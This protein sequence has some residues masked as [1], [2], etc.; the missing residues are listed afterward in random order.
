MEVIKKVEIEVRSRYR[1]ARSAPVVGPAAHI[2][3]MCR[4]RSPARPKG[5]SPGVPE[6]SACNEVRN[7]QHGSDRFVYCDMSR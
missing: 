2:A 5:R 3:L 1:G 7:P 4:P 6:L